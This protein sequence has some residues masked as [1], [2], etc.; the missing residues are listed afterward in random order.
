MNPEANVR[1][2]ASKMLADVLP[3]ALFVCVLTILAGALYELNN[4]LVQ[5]IA[6]NNLQYHLAGTS[7]PSEF[8]V[9][10]IYVIPTIVFTF[11]MAY[12]VK[13]KKKAWVLPVILG[14]A[15]VVSSAM[16][17]LL[18]YWWVGWDVAIA[19]PFFLGGAFL[20][21]T[22]SRIPKFW[23]P[24]L[25][26]PFQV[27]LGTGTAML[28]VLVFPL[29]TLLALCGIMAV[30][31]VYAVLRGP[32]G[33]MVSGMKEGDEMNEEH[34]G[35]INIGN[36]LMA[37]V[38]GSG[39]GLGDIVFYSIITMIAFGLSALTGVLMIAVIALGA[40]ITFYILRTR[41]RLALPGLPIPML[42]GFVVLLGAWV[43]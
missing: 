34:G 7:A 21:S 17:V 29:V 35:R 24:L 4:P 39:I 15:F 36:M 13:R 18:A 31:D 14:T 12:L 2:T 43:H 10:L 6:G 27:W 11:A 1:L 26:L 30:W 16:I 40:F 41:K 32:L 37:Q 3:P 33:K 9:A 23:S 42:F 5:Y 38:G 22:R 28:M 19:I 25:R 20:F 8:S